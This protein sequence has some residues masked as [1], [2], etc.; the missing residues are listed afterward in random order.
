MANDEVER[1]LG[2]PS[3]LGLVVCPCR[4]NTIASADTNLELPDGDFKNCQG[5]EQKGPVAQLQLSNANASV[6]TSVEAEDHRRSTP[7]FW[8]G[9][10]KWQTR[11]WSL[12]RIAWRKRVKRRGA[13]CLSISAPLR[14][15]RIVWASPRFGVDYISR[16]SV[17]NFWSCNCNNLVCL[18]RLRLLFD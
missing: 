12:S 4:K 1:L 5:H 15:C 3:C 17:R 7:G 11:D 6:R 2:Y 18:F 14:D 16:L 10:Y 13:K 8:Q 9:F